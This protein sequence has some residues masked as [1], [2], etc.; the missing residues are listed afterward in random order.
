MT[1]SR[2][3]TAAPVSTQYKA[4]AAAGRILGPLLEEQVDRFTL[5]NGLTVI[6]KPDDSA[7]VSAVQ[8]WVKTGSIHEGENL[9]SGLS[10]FLEHMLFKGTGKRSAR[11]ITALI[12]AN[13]GTINAYTTFDRT[14]YHVDVPNESTSVALDVLADA[15]FGSLLPE[16]EVEK[17]RG[18]IL[19]EI[20]MYLDDPL[21]RLSQTLF[22]TA[23]REHPSRLPVIGYRDLFES[24]SRDELLRYYRSRYAPNNA[25]L[26]V[27]GDLSLEQCHEEVNRYFG[28]LR[29]RKIP[30]V[31]IPPEP[32]QLGYREAANFADVQVSHAGLG[33]KIPGLSHP[34]SPAIKIL[35]SILGH[36]SSSILWRKLR[37]ELKL[38]HDIDASAWNPGSTGLFFVSFTTDAEKREEATK[39][40][41]QELERL[42]RDGVA[43]SLI[44]KTVRQALMAEVQVRRT[45]QGQASRLGAAEVVVGD[46]DY[47]RVY[48]EQL[49]AVTPE[50]V[51]RVAR[52]WLRR[53]HLTSVSL[54]PESSRGTKVAGTRGIAARAGF[55]E[56]TQ[57]NGAV[58]LLQPDRHLPSVHIRAIL[59]GGPLYETARARGATS[60]LATLLTKDTAARTREQVA[61]AIESAGGSFSSFSGNNTL[62]LSLEVLPDDLELGLDLL[63]EAL[64]RPALRPDTF[65][66]EREAEIAGLKED[67]DEIVERGKK[68]FR[69]RF[70]GKHPLAI[71]P[72]G[73]MESLGAMRIEDVQGIYES[74]VAAENIVLSAVGDFDEKT[75]A[76]GLAKIADQLPAGTF[77]PKSAPFDGPAAG[78]YREKMDRNQAVVFEG[79]PD[80]GLTDP[81]FP[82]AEVADELFSGMSSRLF[83]RVREEL[84]LAYFV[85]STRIIGVDTGLFYFYAGTHPAAVEA[86]RKEIAAEVIRVREGGVS[87]EELLRCQRRLKARKRM[88]LQSFGARAMEAGINRLHGLPVNDFKGYDARV[89]AVR[90]K[91]LQ[92]F[93]NEFFRPE[94]KV[95][96]VI[97]PE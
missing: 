74:T 66:R 95:T 18:V 85:S 1:E 70:F 22:E 37:D 87:E 57:K 86:V 29:R 17:E 49:A 60:L 23:F 20:D 3:A 76:R 96:L 72:A 28:G 92:A 31:F 21:S 68:L 4:A 19:R 65:E 45:M 67:W 24:V 51:Q 44:A 81:R 7:P 79:Y 97:G 58:L 80:V 2:G 94:K 73:T 78:E 43:E 25:V 14:V 10:H 34:D 47:P 30:P 82:V 55:R 11:E 5:P 32:E 16:A 48:L 63:E 54:N 39:A 9:G 41:W 12:Q 75:L 89:D 26:V 56:F 13:G 40:V 83:E 88:G 90:V 53:E 84:G 71:E 46:L 64:L 15:V 42:I 77:S 33:F 61:E 35:A 27:V 38:V 52:Q 8:L 36:G 69:E 93:A 50:D 6:C 59:R 62:G 91:H